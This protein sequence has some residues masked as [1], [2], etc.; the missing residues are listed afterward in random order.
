[1]AVADGATL[2][3]IISRSRHFLLQ[4]NGT[5]PHATGHADYGIAYKP[6]G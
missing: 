6:A 4:A 1:M 3:K 2:Q 5:F